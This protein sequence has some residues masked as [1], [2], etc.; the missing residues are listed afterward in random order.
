MFA[1]LV[2]FTALLEKRGA[3]YA[4]LVVTQCLKLLDEIVRKQGGAVDKYQGDRLMA[5]FGYPVPLED[6][7][8]A[9]VDA[10]LAMRQCV[11]D[12]NRD[13]GLEIPLRI[14]IGVNA[15]EMVSGDVA[16]PA[17]REF[18]V[19]GSA[20]N[21]A[22]RLK[23]KAPLDGI[24]VG[25]EIYEQTCERYDFR[26]MEPLALKGLEAPVAAQE[27]LVAREVGRTGRLGADHRA[28][29]DRVGLD[30][31]LDRLRAHV[32]ALRGGRGGVV[33]LIGEEGSG[34]SRL[35]ADLGAEDALEGVATL[36]ARGRATHA[37]RAFHPVAEL[38][39]AWL[40]DA[41]DAPDPVT[42]IA[43]RLDALG[44]AHPGDA[45]ALAAVLE[46]SRRGAG[47][48][49]GDLVE[50]AADAGDLVE[51]AA[52][53]LLRLLGANARRAPQLVVIEDLQWLDAVTLEVLARLIGL[54]ADHP[55]LFLL[56]GRTE[57]PALAAGLAGLP[58]ERSDAIVLAPLA[59]PEQRR[60][61]EALLPAQEASPEVC[62]L[63]EARAGGNPGRIVLASFLA[64]A[65]RSETDRDAG[66]ERSSEA[67]RRR[68]TIL[69]ADITGFTAM[70]ERLG[71]ER[72]YP[73]VAECLELLDT[74][75]RKHGG[76]VDKYLGDCVMALFGVPE[77]IEDAP[78]AAVNAAIEMRR[79]VEELNQERQLETPLGVHS[80]I[81]T[82]LGIAGEISGPLI[83]EFAVMGD[84]V[85]VAD[86]LK[87]LS[88][89]GAIYVGPDTRRWTE[90]HFDY[91][92]VDAIRLPGRAEE[93]PAFE[94]LSTQEQLHRRRAG[95]ER[96]VFSEL[97]GRE[98]EVSQLRERLA[99]L[100]AGTGSIA[101]I[102]A[103]AGIGKSRLTA[104]VMASEQAQAFNW[105][106][107]RSISVGQQLSYHP[108]GDLLRSWADI[109]DADSEP[110]MVA[111]VEASVARL[112]PDA[113]GEIYPLLATVMGL[114]LDPEQRARVDAIPGET[115]DRLV[116]RSLAEL[117]G[118]QASERPVVV[119]FDDLH[120]ADLSSVELLESLLALTAS[121]PIL[122]LN[123]ARP[124][125]P[126]TSGRI[127]ETARTRY[128]DASVELALEPLGPDAARQLIHNLFKHAEIPHRTRQLIVEKTGGNPFY[129][130][131]VVRSLIEEGAVEYVDGS[132]RATEK[133]HHAVIPG[134][135]Q[136]VIM[137]RVDRLE[138]RKREILQVASVV[139][140]SF[141][142]QVL[143]QIFE[144]KDELVR[145]IDEMVDAQ[146]LVSWDRLQGIEHA[147]A[148]PLI[149]E[150]VYD[151]LLMA[152]REELHR[153]V[154][155]AI[156]GA[157]TENV[158]GYHA[159]LAYHFSLG[160]DPERAE[161][162]LFRAG[163]EAARS[164]ASIEALH[165]FREASRLY[166]EMH[167]EGGDPAK[168]ARLERSIA[169]ALYNRGGHDDESAQ[170]FDRALQFLGQPVPESHVVLTA[171]FA[172]DMVAILARLYLLPERRARPPATAFQR[173]LIELMFRRA[174]TQTTSAPTR[175]VYDTMATLRRLARVDPASIPDSGGMYSG[176]TG[177]FS[178]GGISFALGRR[179]L[180]IAGDVIEQTGAQDLHIYYR[181]MRFLHF[182][183]E[184][185]WSEEYEIDDATL[186]Q[187]MREGRLWEVNT[188]LGLLAEKHA[189]RGEFDA[190][191]ERIEQ[192]DRMWEGYEYENAQVQHLAVDTLL[193][194][195]QRNLPEARQAADRYYESNPQD[196]LH[197]VALGWRGE[198]ELVDGDREAADA[199]LARASDIAARIGPASAWHMSSYLKARYLNDLVALEGVL[200]S[201]DRGERRRRERRARASGRAASRV[202]SKIVY[203]GA[204]I[205]RLRGRHAWLHG[206]SAAAMRHWSR[207]LE[208]ARALGLRPELGRL[209]REIGLRLGN[210]R[211]EELSASEHLEQGRR[212]FRE[213][214]LDLDL[215]RLEEGRAD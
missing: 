180:D 122:F 176:A 3:E 120:W 182:L 26:A 170:H 210:D 32:V 52:D 178:Y 54:A 9:A 21:L 183:L 111:K 141:H 97:V 89:S 73:I 33:R 156:E 70:T 201:G 78:R 185:D 202:V 209:H 87:D 189:R 82:G 107:A 25:P 44:A 144:D 27:L 196:A 124:G 66:R 118:R 41:E 12:Y 164:A 199:S 161:E 171:R 157:L 103:E 195:E 58:P 2:G 18:H 129:V 160:R 86:H 139:G 172:W 105:L 29:C 40:A 197:M 10:A 151:S 174:L 7:A 94:L 55:V 138:T 100:A 17:I 30:A 123:V 79:R 106:E 211:L 115:V 167:G 59:P 43:R 140:R 71:A 75:A 67:E 42:E 113:G 194:L 135:V 131:E 69:F 99:A 200:G 92:P 108:F 96:Q 214:G 134:T 22:A 35:L 145:C 90:E 49:A 121:H 173:E 15:G 212:L 93:I 11:R 125:F 213:L 34:K 102:V 188:Y 60:L 149:Q 4:Y 206:R 154:G 132:F 136:E 28:Y 47:A 203:R 117:L 165:F 146:F 14:Q 8:G 1:D 104:E 19:L 65:L 46:A 190:A 193:Q 114:R 119:V 31:E 204:E 126:N 192:V 109:T 84:P 68:S 53:A 198:A 63:I 152:R 127:L 83:R 166:F 187:G 57:A 168:K 38:L 128:A 95:I 72:A 159:M 155:E 85:D 191:R 169:L 45:D 179:F 23:A 24:Y 162:S 77:A 130:E 48:D 133:I 88:P 112:L 16:G 50:R 5:L 215:K 101:S 39:R 116:R 150:V 98:A 175:F 184:G 207:G 76:T 62:A 20:V 81:H 64:P 80:G 74:I 142:Q 137:A 153:R 37:D 163:D 56:T 148:H 110:E 158:P 147:F 208:R 91:Q 143:L 205:D 61:V 51:R 181:C 6:P 36:Q 177:I 13:I 186:E